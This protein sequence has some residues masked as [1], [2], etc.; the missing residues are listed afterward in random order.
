MNL[1]EPDYPCP[2]FPTRECTGGC[3]TQCERF[4]WYPG[5]H[6]PGYVLVALISESPWPDLDK[7]CDGEKPEHEARW[8]I[9]TEEDTGDGMRQACDTHLGDWV[10]TVA[11]R[12]WEV[13]PGAG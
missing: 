12:L 13:F 3:D 5:Q 6:R 4:P 11:A 1:K 8:V 9:W 10:S 2:N 7:V